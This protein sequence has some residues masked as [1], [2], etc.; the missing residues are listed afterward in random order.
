MDSPIMVG[1]LRQLFRRPACQAL[2]GAPATR[3]HAIAAR[4]GPQRAAE[5]RRHMATRKPQ[6]KM[7]QGQKNDGQWQQRSDIA[8]KDRMSEFESYPM[9][10]SADLRD[11]KLRPKRVK[12]LLRDFIEGEFAA[13]RLPARWGT[14]VKLASARTWH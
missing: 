6:S 11:H 7:E 1:L 10:T 8:P 4:N 5:Q 12:M 14:T 3:S 13:G 2:R 9:V